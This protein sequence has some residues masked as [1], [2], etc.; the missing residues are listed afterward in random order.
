M[1]RAQNAELKF[2][3]NGLIFNAISDSF[4]T[5]LVLSPQG[6]P[7]VAIPNRLQFTPE[8]YER[9]NRA[10]QTYWHPQPEVAL[11]AKPAW[12]LNTCADPDS[13][14]QALLTIDMA[15][16]TAPP[17]FNHPRAVMAAR[18]DI[19][20][21]ALAGIGG[22]EV[23]KSRRF[24]P[25][26]PRSFTDCF[27]QGGFQYPVTV[28]P[29]AA[30]NGV[31]RIWINHPMDWQTLFNLAGGGH[32]HIMVQAH[33][34]EAAADWALR[35]VF[36]GQGGAVETLRHRIKPG[37]SASV[38]PVQKALVET[39]FKTA[40]RRI[41]LDFWTLDL[42][43]LAPNHL[44]LLDVSAGFFVPDA[45]DDIAQMRQVSLTIADQIGPRL[46]ALLAQP[47]NWREDA[48]KLPSVEA[49]MQR[50]GA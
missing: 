32:H 23:P 31:K 26:G 35:M 30:R 49:L 28:Q 38:L 34:D 7:E 25:L 16:A 14:A 40:F 18:R 8:L 4:L 6:A 29:S 44:R 15:Y 43:A 47:Q 17:I 41:P 48:R 45:A 10:A 36:V 5:R 20:G 24:L 3:R 11:P 33:P 50:Y 39:V 13:F 21:V 42:M 46:S 37:M 27:E 12:V 9:L 22:L 19:A 1:A 2:Q